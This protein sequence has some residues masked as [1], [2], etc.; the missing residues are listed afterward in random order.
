MAGTE[1]MRTSVDN[2]VLKI[3]WCDG[4]LGEWSDLQLAPEF[5]TMT[6]TA[7]QRLDK[8]KGFK[9]ESKGKGKGPE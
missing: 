6:S 5:L 3:Q 1:V 7:Q 2:Y 9:G 8:V 4:D